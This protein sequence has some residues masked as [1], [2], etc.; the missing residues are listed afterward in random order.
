MAARKIVIKARL[1]LYDHGRI[2][3]LKQTKPNGGN[4]SLVG[5]T[6]EAH[7]LARASLIRE[8]KEEAGIQL[9]EKDLVLVHVLHQ[10]K[11]K[12]EDRITLYFKAVR[13]EGKLRARETDKF[14]D[15]RWFPL[16]QLPNNL[17]PKV[18]QALRNYRL[19]IFYSEMSS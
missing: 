19:G 3:L 14:K 6:V 1:I 7:E 8:S 5:G 2:M 9:Q 15:T 10:K 12:E 18:R 17:T 4:Y 16:D 13:W 11:R